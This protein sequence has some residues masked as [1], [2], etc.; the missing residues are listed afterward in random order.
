MELRLQGATIC[1][2]RLEELIGE[3]GMATVWRAVHPSLSKVAGAGGSV[4]TRRWAGEAFHDRGSLT[5]EADEAL[6]HHQ[7]KSRR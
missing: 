2:Y 3:G 7:K 1:G 6:I 5:D 4:C